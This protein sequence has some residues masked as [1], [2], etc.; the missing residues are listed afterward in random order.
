MVR[1]LPIRIGMEQIVADIRYALRSLA[2]SRTLAV[3]AIPSLA[4]GIGAVTVVFSLVNSLRLM[5]LPV[6][7]PSS[8]VSV[9]TRRAGGGMESW[10]P[11]SV[12][13][14]VE[15]DN[16]VFADVAP[17]AT[18]NLTVNAGDAPAEIMMVAFQPGNF[19]AMLGVPVIR[20]RALVP[21]DDEPGSGSV[22]VISHRFWRSRF[23]GSDS[24]LSAVLTVQGIRIPIVGVTAPGFEGLRRPALN[25]DGLST[26][27]NAQDIALPFSAYARFHSG[28]PPASLN[29][30]A[31]LKDAAT[32]RAA[33]LE[34]S[35]IFART[36]PDALDPRLSEAERRE[37]LSQ[38]V[39][40]ELAGRGDPFRWKSYQ[41]P[42][43]VLGGVAAIVLLVACMNI[44]S[45]LLVRA[46]TRTREMTI[47]AALG[48]NRSRIIRQL[49]VESLIVAGLGG[50][51]GIGVVVWLEGVLSKLFWLGRPVAADWRVFGFALAAAIT[52]A[53][54]I[55]LLPGVRT[56]RVDLASGLRDRSSAAPAQRS[57]FRARRFVVSLQVA[58]SLVLVT[59]GGLLVTTIRNLDRVPLGFDPERVLLFWLYR[60]APVGDASTSSAPQFSEF[61]RRFESLPGVARV[62]LARHHLLQPGDYFSNVSVIGPSHDASPGGAAR[63]VS[64]RVALN[65]VAPAFFAAM[66]VP[67]LAGR[68]FNDRDATGSTRVALVSREF[69]ARRFPAGNAIGNRIVF[70]D[71][72]LRRPVEIVGI[73][74]DTRYYAIRNVEAA[75]TEQV[76]VPYA[77][78]PPGE[79]NQMC[80][81]LRTTLDPMRVLPAVQREVQAMQRDL[82]VAFATTQRT[83]IADGERRERLLATLVAAFAAVALVLSTAGIYGMLSYSVALRGPEFGVR[84][85]LGAVKLDIYNIVL[86]EVSRVMLLGF[87][88]GIPVAFASTRLIRGMLFGV[89]LAN[90]TAFAISATLLSALALSASLIT[91]RRAARI[92][93]M[94]SL[95]RE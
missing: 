4:L 46:T 7:D 20:G 88:V 29:I 86:A 1:I 90:W 32:R 93:P 15:Q 18:A 57:A 78:A 95:R 61:A 2:R 8:L 37:T 82:P 66:R 79:V 49:L 92:D 36:M 84:M 60:S 73:V 12:V 83:V 80:F 55:G 77:Q 72:S 58:M 69:A 27:D 62:S 14:A 38:P 67:V 91:A 5:E 10:F 22:A 44:V 47:C 54:L 89:G 76:Y 50:T 35:A 9:H 74:G 53:A 31:R 23:G 64:S 48:A 24:A 87:A 21:A 17:W 52:A 45:L 13:R 33:E 81:I 40:I 43:A 16:H 19:H 63:R 26:R 39:A 3:I 70:D 94:A 30:A 42:L 71:D 11:A 34:V 85:A 41:R 6:R 65:F 59:A 68:E 25:P 28:Q 75:P 56:A 51:I